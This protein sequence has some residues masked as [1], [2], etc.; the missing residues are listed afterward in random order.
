MIDVQEYDP[1]SRLLV[2]LTLD[3]WSVKF[4]YSFFTKSSRTAM[5]DV[6]SRKP[7]LS[8]TKHKR[9]AELLTGKKI[10]NDNVIKII[11]DIAGISINMKNKLE[12]LK[13]IDLSKLP[14]SAKLKSIK[15]APVASVAQ[16]ASGSML[17]VKRFV[18]SVTL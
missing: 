13:F 4:D 18:E 16:S 2:G 9:L 12:N 17:T 7:K 15:T 14:S 10:D 5:S 11:A 1:E 6:F 8:S 3:K